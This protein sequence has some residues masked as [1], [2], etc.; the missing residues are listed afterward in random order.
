MKTAIITGITG[1]D[2]AY[3]AKLLLSKNYKVIGLSRKPK[4]ASTLWRLNKLQIIDNLILLSS[5]IKSLTLLKEYA[6][7]EVYHLA[8]QSSVASSFLK[9]FVTINSN[10]L[11][12]LNWLEAIREVNCGTKFYNA[13]SSEIFGKSDRFSRDEKSS[14]HPRSPY[15]VAKLL[16]HFT[17]INYREAYKIF[18]CNGILFNHES[19]LRGKE[20]V[21]QKIAENIVD[22]HKKRIDCF[23]IGNLSAK[24]DWG[25]ALDYVY[26]MYLVLQNE[27]ADDFV[28]ATG[29]LTSVREFITKA[30]KVVNI[31]IIWEGSG[32]D[33]IGRCSQTNSILVKVNKKFFR[34]T[35]FEHSLGNPLK[36]KNILKWEPKIKLD[37]LLEE[38]INNYL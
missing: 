10:G 24:R 32:L 30:F 31:N 18:A 26:G 11:Q 7:D 17:T 2:G 1:Q 19:S 20:F 36:A 13:S 23:E 35:D 25:H 3:L 33:E 5:D 4:D 21:T 28:L 12:A 6:P 22:I 37:E 14:Y 16:S 15:A 8:G 38:M 9:P 29:V 34:P 27:I